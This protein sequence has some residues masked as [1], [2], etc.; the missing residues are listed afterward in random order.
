MVAAGSSG[1]SNAPFALALFQEIVEPPVADHI[2]GLA[3]D[4]A[5]LVDC[6]LGHRDGAPAFDVDRRAAE[7]VDDPHAIGVAFLAGGDKFLRR[8]LK[9]GRPHLAV[10][11]PDGAEAVPQQAVAEHRPV[12]DQ[13]ADRELVRGVAGARHRGSRLACRRTLH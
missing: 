7:L 6:H 9:P 3:V 11:M 2:A 5:A 10:R 13:L 1:T 4:R 8:A 12:L